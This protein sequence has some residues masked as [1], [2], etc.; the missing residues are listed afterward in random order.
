MILLKTDYTLVIDTNSQ[1]ENFYLKLCAYCTGFVSENEK[2]LSYSD[3]FYLEE[4]IE[5]D[6][7]PKGKLADEKNPFYGFIAQKYVQNA[8]SPASVWINKK[9]GMN[10]DGDLAVLTEQNYSDYEFAA[11]CSVGIFFQ[12]EPTLQ[13]II[14]IK[15]RASKFFENMKIAAKVEG[16]RLITYTKHAEEK[17][18]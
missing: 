10:E 9:Y 17:D 14:I 18:I 3:L 1:S 13:Q 16:F 12:I 15:R 6:P 4:G 7:N 5:D 8:L 11:P 2:D